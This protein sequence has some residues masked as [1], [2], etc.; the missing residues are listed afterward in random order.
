MVIERSE[1]V[2]QALRK[3]NGGRA[4]F[5]ACLI[6]P[7]GQAAECKYTFTFDQNSSI[8]AGMRLLR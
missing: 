3:Y 7:S 8:G 5:A 4:D 6:E 1:I 2:S